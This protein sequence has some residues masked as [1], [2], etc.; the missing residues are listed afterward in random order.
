MKLRARYVVAVCLT[1]VVLGKGLARLEAIA[2]VIES[3]HEQLDSLPQEIAEKLK[4]DDEHVE[5]SDDEDDLDTNSKIIT[6][7]CSVGRF[8]PFSRYLPTCLCFR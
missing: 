2:S 6:K 7:L 3:T 1:H 5:F 8:T 4:V